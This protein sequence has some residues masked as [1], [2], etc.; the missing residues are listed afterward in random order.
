[1]K[2]KALIISVVTASLLFG[3]LVSEAGEEANFS[4]AYS[5]LEEGKRSIYLSDEEG[6]LTC[7]HDRVQFVS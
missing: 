5:Y 4:L 2:I 6:R 7:P 3:L 1:M